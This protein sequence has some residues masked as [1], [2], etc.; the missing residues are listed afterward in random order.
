MSDQNKNTNPASQNGANPPADDGLQIN[1][2]LPEQQAQTDIS[3]LGDVISNLQ[4][5]IQEEQ[6]QAE[7]LEV[8]NLELPSAS[9]QAIPEIDLS[10][11]LPQ[12][13]SALEKSSDELAK[14]NEE[15][16]PPQDE[17]SNPADNISQKIFEGP[18]QTEE[19]TPATQDNLTIEISES[20]QQD[21]APEQNFELAK[22]EDLKL[23]ITP[24]PTDTNEAPKEIEI[25]TQSEE[26]TTEPAQDKTL[27]DS[28][29]EK[30]VQSKE[31]IAE[32]QPSEEQTKELNSDVAKIQAEEQT[33]KQEEEPTSETKDKV[34]QITQV[35]ESTIKEQIEETSQ[36]E[37]QANEIKSESAQ[38]KQ[39]E[40]PSQTSQQLNLEEQI[41]QQDE[42]S[43]QIEEVNQ[44]T[45]QSLSSLEGLFEG[46]TDKTASSAEETIPTSLEEAFD[47]PQ[48]TASPKSKWIN[49]MVIAIG[50]LSVLILGGAAV[51]IASMPD[52]FANLLHKSQPTTPI[53][54]N[55]AQISWNFEEADN[56]QE[57]PAQPQQQ[58]PTITG[59]QTD[60]QVEQQE[61]EPLMLT[62]QDLL[63]R[64]EDTQML[65]EEVD[66]ETTKDKI[67]AKVLSKKIQ[68]MI[69]QEDLTEEDLQKI[70]NLLSQLENLIYGD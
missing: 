19:A 12:E 24:Q 46:Q 47:E 28:I 53:I 59:E 41:N 10:L 44:Q 43:Q 36:T 58:E 22:P 16:L 18:T 40:T 25:S 65:L 52:L 57:Q 35:E 37:E 27:T 23:D 50:G 39:D 2:D 69:Y 7:N 55:N 38:I 9:E 31:Q 1:L 63:T 42:K 33:D 49:K 30:T 17:E 45:Q 68:N 66:F 48:E 5:D 62:Q 11:D 54:T 34:E 8:P 56:Q 3:D 51:M 60:E 21:S 32:I 6:K 20:P 70:D 26:P 29:E 61:E 4:L 67:R 14:I 15:I 64:F 13:E